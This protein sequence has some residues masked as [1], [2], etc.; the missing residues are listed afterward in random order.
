M[1]MMGKRSH[2][3]PRQIR[4]ATITCRYCS[5]EAMFHCPDAGP[6]DMFS[7]E[8]A[9]LEELKCSDCHKKWFKVTFGEYKWPDA[10]WTRDLESLRGWL[11]QQLAAREQ[12]RKE[13]RER[14]ARAREALMSRLHVRTPASIEN[15]SRV[16]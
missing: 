5:K 6:L 7:S 11:D 13:K 10:K 9:W 15:P 3:D 2:G 14:V 8:P 4:V 16:I 1:A 12:R